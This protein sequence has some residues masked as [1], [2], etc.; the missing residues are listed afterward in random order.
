MKKF[1]TSQRLQQL[2]D[3]RGLR[4]VDILAAVEPFC[5]EYDVKLE[6]NALS[7]Y[8]AGKHQ[9]D[10]HRLHVLA[11]ALNVSEAWLMGYEVSMM[12]ELAPIT[13]EDDERLHLCVELFKMLSNEQKDFILQAIRGLLS[14]RQ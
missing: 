7:Q 13:V 14:A 1:T 4:Q 10:Q 2:M 6:K 8:V 5:R 11:M 9:P 12:K 3:E